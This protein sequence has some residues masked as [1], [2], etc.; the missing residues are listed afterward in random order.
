MV[1]DD[2]AAQS[3][4]LFLP[5]DYR[6][7]RAWPILYC[8]DPAAR[9][10]LAVERFQAAAEKHGWIVAGSNNSRN[11]SLANSIASAEALVRDTHRRLH[12]DDRRL[13]AAGFSGGACCACAAAGA[14]KFSGVIACSGG[15]PYGVPSSVAFV[16]FGTAGTSDF[17]YSEMKDVDARLAVQQ[18]PHRVAIFNG[19]HEWL[20]E[21]LAAE[22]IDWLE[23]QAM[24]SGLRPKDDAFIATQFHQREQAI[25]E[26][27]IPGE[28]YVASIGLVADFDGLADIS[29]AVHRVSALKNSKPVRQF[30]AAETKSLKQEQTW[31][32]QL[33]TIASEARHPPA[34]AARRR[35]RASE[36]APIL[37]PDFS[38][39]PSRDPAGNVSGAPPALRDWVE[40]VDDEPEEPFDALRRAVHELQRKSREN[41]AARRALNRVFFTFF[42]RSRLFVDEGKYSDAAGLLEVAAVI[43]PEVPAVDFEQARLSLLQGDTPNARRLLD[44]AIAKGFS[45]G[46]GIALLR[47]KLSS[48]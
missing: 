13:Y 20:P 8:F 26:M 23:L 43:R 30:L 16:F 5:S 42:E 12:L 34:P 39:G 18:V 22:A 17:N 40:P 32:D 4:A 35:N 44:S 31:A 1:C 41:P 25:A 3:Y 10:R 2:D 36:A 37:R 14:G 19:D 28:A 6:A 9:G 29:E 48:P 45:D 27:K 7:D 24:R 46:E 21:P 33:F 15:F 11:G 38:G 47:E